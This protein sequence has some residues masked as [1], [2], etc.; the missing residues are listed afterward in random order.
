MFSKMHCNLTNPDGCQ[1]ERATEKIL[2]RARQLVDVKKEDGFSALHL[3]ALNNHRD[4]AE[5]LI[6]EG[7]CDVNIRNNRNQTPLQLAV[8]QGHTDLVQL[9]VDEGADVNMEDE[10][11]DTAMHV[12]LL[13]PQLANVM[14]TPSAGGSSTEEGSEGCSS[15]SLYCRVRIDG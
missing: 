8:T 12:A 5:V 10:D 3:A 2:A 13:R 14:L 6:K 15:T 9:L 7:R 1:T 11:G 4:V